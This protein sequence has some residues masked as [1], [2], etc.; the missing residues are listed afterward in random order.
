MSVR[1][2]YGGSVVLALAGGALLLI[3]GLLMS[4]LVS[5]ID[6]PRGPAAIA[7]FGASA[8]IAALVLVSALRSQSA[9]LR[10]PP[11]L[12]SLTI[13]GLAISGGYWLVASDRAEALEPL[14]ALIAMAAV[15]TFVGRILVR[16]TPDRRLPARPLLAAM[17]WGM[18]GATTLALGM[19]IVVAGGLFAAVVGGLAYADIDL[20]SSLVARLG[21]EQYMEGAVGELIATPT[22]AIA[23]VAL[24]GLLAPMT[25]ELTKLLG[26]M[27]VFRR[28][29]VTRY[30]VFATGAA[31]GLGFAVVETF[32][33][34]GLPAGEQW[35]TIL[36]LRAPVV[37]IHVTASSL[38]ACGWYIQQTRGGYGMVGYFAASAL[39]HAAWNTL[40]V[41]LMI[42]A[43]SAGESSA[44]VD[45]GT[46][47]VMLGVV[48]M[49]FSLFG[50]CVIWTVG[51]AR[52][53]GREHRDPTSGIA[54]STHA[55]LSRPTRPFEPARVLVGSAPGEV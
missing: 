40:F 22:V 21:D 33:I 49:M 5:E 29:V 31:V 10:F 12:V 48:G 51:G 27:L 47:L 42:V 11:L 35:T 17:A 7:G 20:V 41:V 13:F 2:L 50:V 9:S 36:L 8:L 1:S 14:L 18:A 16:W 38:A 44:D 4:G 45:A 6:D 46:A 43:G 28:R 32:A 26:V 37:I 25:E 23:A 39:V 53:W 19:Q 24:V 55:G 34:Y 54:A 3:Y 30:L 52:R 15:L